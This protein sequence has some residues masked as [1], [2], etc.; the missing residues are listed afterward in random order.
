MQLK[1]LSLSFLLDSSKKSNYILMVSRARRWFSAALTFY[2]LV[3]I[4]DK[5]KE[6]NPRMK[7]EKFFCIIQWKKENITQSIYTRMTTRRHRV[8][9]SVNNFFSNVLIVVQ[10]LSKHNFSRNFHSENCHPEIVSNTSVAFVNSFE[11][12]NNSDRYSHWSSLVPIIEPFHSNVVCLKSSNDS[13][14]CMYSNHRDCHW[15]SFAVDETM[16]MHV[17]VWHANDE[18]N[19]WHTISMLT[20]ISDWSNRYRNSLRDWWSTWYSKCRIIWFVIDRE[21]VVGEDWKKERW[22]CWLLRVDEHFDRSCRQWEHRRSLRWFESTYLVCDHY[23]MK[24]WDFYWT[25]EFAPNVM[26]EWEITK[27]ENKL[28]KEWEERSKPSLDRRIEKRISFEVKAMLRGHSIW[29]NH[30]GYNR[31]EYWYREREED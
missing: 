11:D 7:Q 19:M 24:N 6:K 25:I 29:L 3:S 26:L 27:W 30:C 20:E 14:H 13:L 15:F 1:S 17:D 22:E 21:D 10:F 16:W 4:N 9:S 23:R 12:N 18:L 2:D 28:T 31:H 5:S 8:F